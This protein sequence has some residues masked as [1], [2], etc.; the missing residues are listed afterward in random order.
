[1]STRFQ[2]K[3]YESGRKKPRGEIMQPETSG[4]QNVPPYR[5]SEDGE[6][7][8]T[9]SGESIDKPQAKSTRI[10]MIFIKLAVRSPCQPSAKYSPLHPV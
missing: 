5:K 6:R 3:R 9:S 4:G 7:F 1:L 8:P 10:L 2:K